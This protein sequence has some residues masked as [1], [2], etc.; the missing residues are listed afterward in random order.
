MAD[1]PTF[2]FGLL[3][4]GEGAP[5]AAAAEASDDGG[6]GAAAEPEIEVTPLVK[7]ERIE[8]KTGEEDEDVLLEVRAKLYNWGEGNAGEQWKHR[9]TGPVKILKH[10]ETGCVRVLMRRDKTMKICA[11]HVVQP[12]MKLEGMPSMPDKAWTYSAH[13]DYSDHCG[14]TGE[15]EVKAVTM[16]LR[17]KDKA[18]ADNF[19]KVFREGQEAYVPSPVKSGGGGAAAA[20]GDVEEFV[21]LAV[22]LP[23]DDSAV[24]DLAGKLA[25]L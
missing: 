15:M 12:Y 17:F 24:S 7:L 25:E 3:A 2:T 19:A 16:A 13:S 23:K 9:G 18:I 5:A 14:E 20:G 11:N 22:L 10:K 6:G 4:P 21:K 8:V 1:V